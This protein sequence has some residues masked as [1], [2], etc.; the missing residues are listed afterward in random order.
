MLRTN[1]S[2]RPFYNERALQGVIGVAAA[3]A[4]VLTLFNVTQIVLLTRRQ[5]ALSSQATAAEARAAE[6]RAKAARTR[7]T[8]NANQI[9]TISGAAR[10]ANII[11]GQRLF[12]W[13]TSARRRP[14]RHNHHLD[15][16]LLRRRRRHRA[17]HGEPREFDGVQRGL[18]HQRRTG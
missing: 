3:I 18:S 13:T 5:S 15:D 9:D 1:L 7:Q 6:L 16:G 11:I 12:S 2:T 8:L 14:R 10:E 4:V 17:V